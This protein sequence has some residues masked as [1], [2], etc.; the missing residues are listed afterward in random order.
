MVSEVV[1]RK[2][3]LDLYEE[4]FEILILMFMSSNEKLKRDEVSEA[5]P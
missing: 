3:A 1:A 5:H 4:I 2:L